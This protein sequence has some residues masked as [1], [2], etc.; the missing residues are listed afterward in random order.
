MRFTQAATDFYKNV[1]KEAEATG[2][3]PKPKPKPKPKTQRN[4]A[5]FELDGEK[6]VIEWDGVGDD[7]DVA[8]VVNGVKAEVAYKSDSGDGKYRGGTPLPMGTPKPQP[9]PEPK[10]WAQ[11]AAESVGKKL[12]ETGILGKP[13]T[14]PATGK[15]T[16]RDLWEFASIKLAEDRQRYEQ[17]NGP[18]PETDLVPYTFNVNGKPK[19][20]KIPFWQVPELNAYKGGAIP[21]ERERNQRRLAETVQ[22]ATDIT[23]SVKSAVTDNPITNTLG[24][25]E[26]GAMGV[27]APGSENAYKNVV[28]DKGVV[29]HLAGIIA[30]ALN[31]PVE[32]A[33]EMAVITNPGVSREQAL[34]ATANIL[35]QGGTLDTVVEQALRRG[36]SKRSAAIIEANSGIT[37]PKGPRIVDANAPRVPTPEAPQ[38]GQQTGPFKPKPASV[39]DEVLGEQN[40]PVKPPTSPVETPKPPAKG[41]VAFHGTNAEFDTFDPAMINSRESFGDY[42]GE[43]FFFHKDKTTASKYGKNVKQVELRLEN[44]LV[45]NTERD[46]QAWRDSFGGDEKFFD[47]SPAEVQAE[48]KRRGYDGLMDNLYGQYAVFDADQIK[49]KPTASTVEPPA[50]TVT[51]TAAVAESATTPTTPKVQAGNKETFYNWYPLGGGDSDGKA[52]IA[53]AFNTEFGSDRIKT[54][55]QL[56]AS[57]DGMLERVARALDEDDLGTVRIVDVASYFDGTGTVKPNAGSVVSLQVFPKNGK[58]GISLLLSPDDAQRVARAIEQSKRNIETLRAGKPVD[59]PTATVKESLTVQPATSKQSLQV[60]PT[61][62]TSARQADVGTSTRQADIETARQELGLDPRDVKTE[63][64]GEWVA[65][66]ETLKGRE[67]AIAE[68]IAK[69]PRQLTKVEEIALGKRFY[70]AKA[71]RD[72]AAKA[73]DSAAYDQLDDE[74]QKIARALDTSGSEWG[75]QGV[76]RQIELASDT[77]EFGIRRR[78][79]RASKRPLTKSETEAAQDLADEVERLNAKIAELEARPA[80]GPRKRTR[81]DIQ[82][83][84]KAASDRIEMKLREMAKSQVITNDPLGVASAAQT[85]QRLKAIAPEIAEIARTYVDEGILIL[86][87]VAKKVKETLSGMG[88]D[89]TEDEIKAVIAGKVRTPKDVEKTLSDWEKVK[90]QASQVFTDERLRLE[91]EQR[92]VKAEIKQAE[93][94]KRADLEAELSEYR[95]QEAAR[96]KAETD[97]RREVEAEARRKKTEAGAEYRK[98]WRESLGGERASVLNQ[99][100]RL[101]EKLQTMT[102]GEIAKAK[103]ERAK[104]KS[105]ELTDTYVQRDALLREVRLKEQALKAEAEPKGIVTQVAGELK[106]ALATGDFSWSALQGSFVGMAN[107]K[108]WAQGLKKS[109]QAAVTSPE[110]Y[111]R[112]M[113][114]YRQLPNWDKIAASGVDLPG[115][116]D[117][118]ISEFLPGSVLDNAPV[119]GKIRK[120]SDQAFRA[121]ATDTRIKILDTWINALESGGMQLDTETLKLLGDAVNTMTGKPSGKFGKAMGS[122]GAGNVLFA[123]GYYV[124]QFEAATWKPVRDAFAFARKTG[125]YKPLKLMAKEYGKIYGGWAAALAGVSVALDAYAKSTGNTGNESWRVER[126]PRS[127]LFGK[128]YKQDAD[129]NVVAVDF[130]PPQITFPV[131]LMT[132]LLDGKLGTDGKV[133]D[134]PFDRQQA[135]GTVLEG[136]YSPVPRSVFGAIDSKRATDKA[137]ETGGAAKYPFDKNMD[138]RTLEGVRNMAV[139]T[140]TPLSW[141]QALETVRSNQLSPW[142][143]AVLAITSMGGRGAQ[144]YKTKPIQRDPRKVPFMD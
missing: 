98:W 125:N 5:E 136:K 134:S 93:K 23:E 123:P 61:T 44:P 127:S 105:P 91:A 111:A 20:I 106:G 77:S 41:V 62:P 66:A 109:V 116:F 96:K 131:K 122:T 80:E 135:L 97:F 19:T 11:N 3:I 104:P 115:V 12:V 10:T 65:Q 84:R 143:K 52:A 117:S 7:A 99:I 16:E 92:R 25:L 86:D 120:G 103:A 87:D 18:T 140:F 48:A 101:K 88:V 58:D 68:G 34:R 63:T 26:T 129:G 29:G 76:A 59:T 69:E 126:D 107:P 132:Q 17:A 124:S 32:V 144:S 57:V 22:R 21:S 142:E 90:R 37:P 133:S 15:R 73:G 138:P 128:A 6:F 119:Y 9:K 56:S 79:E 47:L 60:D 27:I 42:V 36:L 50:Q 38:I 33:T 1:R 78:F 2:A 14:A 139:G 31:V 53:A 130:M 89:A 70:E 64:V 110:E 51:P 100:D 82:T 35:I 94:A 114:S 121:A 113:E 49:T 75:R 39:L 46:A 72:E 112:M 83:R 55:S 118:D 102:P 71:L 4:V 141:Q 74:L 8:R 54:A 28:G 95:K 30:G 81:E 67:V 40:T 45:I 43:G 108:A 24:K 137:N 13:P 85:A